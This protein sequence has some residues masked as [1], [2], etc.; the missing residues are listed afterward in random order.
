MPPVFSMRLFDISRL[1]IRLQSQ[2]A[3]NSMQEHLGR[4]NVSD[5]V[6][7]LVAERRA[8]LTS[9]KQFKTRI[10][11]F[12]AEELIQLA[13]AVLDTSTGT[14]TQVDKAI[15]GYVK[16]NSR[17]YWNATQGYH[18]ARCSRYMSI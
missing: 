14:S 16:Q 7:Q 13:V 11:E 4:S 12:S 2:I 1:E 8:G 9:L 18:S 5:R 10:E 15:S 17:S 3:I 6:S